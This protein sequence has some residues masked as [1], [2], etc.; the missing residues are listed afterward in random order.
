MTTFAIALLLFQ[1]QLGGASGIVTKPGGNEPLPGATVILSPAGSS[2][3]SG[4]RSTITRLKL[5]R[6]RLPQ[7]SL[8]PVSCIAISTRFAFGVSQS[9]SCI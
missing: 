9:R 5:L 1:V 6:R 3:A 7:S 2:Q 4:I 8:S